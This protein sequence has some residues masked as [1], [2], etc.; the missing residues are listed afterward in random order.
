[1]VSTV[2]RKPWSTYSTTGQTH[3]LRPLASLVR[4]AP[5]THPPAWLA[6]AVCGGTRYAL[7]ARCA[8]RTWPVLA[9]PA[10]CFIV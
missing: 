9:L 10:N 7:P 4:L 2:Q 3:E 6:V 1:M 5:G 8:V